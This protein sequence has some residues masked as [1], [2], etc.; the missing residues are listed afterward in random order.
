MR[1][2]WIFVER[3]KEFRVS[4]LQHVG[5]HVDSWGGFQVGHGGFPN[6]YR[7]L[8]GDLRVVTSAA[9]AP[10]APNISRLIVPPIAP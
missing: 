9:S 10:P 6:L 8:R 3:N 1:S 7:D 2:H 5:S 4:L